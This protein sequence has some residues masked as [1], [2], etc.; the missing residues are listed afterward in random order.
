MP[1]LYVKE[2]FYDPRQEAQYDDGSRGFVRVR[3][4]HNERAYSGAAYSPDFAFNPASGAVRELLE[5]YNGG[6]LPLSYSS[7]F[8]PVK[9]DDMKKQLK[10]TP[11]F[12]IQFTLATEAK[13]K[14]VISA[15]PV[16]GVTLTTNGSS[17]LTDKE[18]AQLTNML[19]TAKDKIS[20]WSY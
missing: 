5:A 8:K 7:L 10:A 16:N 11:K 9:K 12:T 4:A 18:I 13:K 2:N 17:K 19:Q 20:S 15:D 6:A 1:L 3:E 14:I